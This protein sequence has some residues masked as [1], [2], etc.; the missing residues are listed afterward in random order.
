MIGVRLWVRASWKILIPAMIFTQALV[1]WNI[2]SQ[3]G[4]SLPGWALDWGWMLKVWAGGTLL[5]SP[6]ASAATVLLVQRAWRQPAD[7]L[8]GVLMRA[9]RTRLDIVIAVFLL[10]LA[11]QVVTLGFACVV[12]WA[13]GAD[14]SGATLPWQLF[15]GPSALLAATCL[16]ALIGEFWKDPWAAPVS[17]IAVFLSRDVFLGNGYPQL[18]TTEI[19]TGSAIPWHPMQWHLQVTALTNLAVGGACLA[20]TRWHVEIRGRRN[21]LWLVGSL[22]LLGFSILV[23]WSFVTS[24]SVYTYEPPA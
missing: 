15:V 2:P 9:W 21:A 18:F 1:L 13:K 6:V 19:P 14:L 8:V 17:A 24:H 5:T 20:L 11:A 12:C 22:V 3:P 4:S 23:M 7:A 16:G 10:G